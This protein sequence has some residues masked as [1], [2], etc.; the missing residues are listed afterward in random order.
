MKSVQCLCV[1]HSKF[2]FTL[3]LTAFNWAFRMCSTWLLVI[4]TTE[5][6]W[7]LGCTKILKISFQDFTERKKKT[8]TKK[9]LCT[10]FCLH[11]HPFI[12]E[13][14]YLHFAFNLLC[15]TTWQPWW[16]FCNYG[17][18]L[19]Q[20]VPPGSA[21]Y[22]IQMIC[23]SLSQKKL[24]SSFHVLALISS[25]FS[26]SLSCSPVQTITKRMVH[27]VEQ[28]GS[29]VEMKCVVQS[30]WKSPA[31]NVYDA[32][33]S[34]QRTHTEYPLVGTKMHPWHIRCKSLIATVL[35]TS[36]VLQHLFC[37]CFLQSNQGIDCIFIQPC[38]GLTHRRLQD[39]SFNIVP[40]TSGWYQLC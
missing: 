9:L 24:I 32:L 36:Y 17:T 1:L 4:L 38:L 18:D 27:Q 16:K 39:H 29:K 28:R 14:S 23:F 37:V 6:Q 30:V 19:W 22:L 8:T 12:S 21:C 35:H 15:E 13:K 33:E 2:D 26:R 40:K 20:P 5:V 31:H 3:N 11:S 10:S 34:G 7:S 25:I